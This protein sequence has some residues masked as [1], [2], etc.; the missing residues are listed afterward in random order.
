MDIANLKIQIQSITDL[1]S[2]Y[3]IEALSEIAGF[4][5]NDGKLLYVAKDIYGYPYEGIETDYLKLQTHV[6]ISA[7]KNNQ[8]FE[9]DYYNIIIYK[10]AIDDANLE[11]FV[12]LCSIHS[13]NADELNF[14]EFFYSL[15]ALF[16][17]PAEQ[18]F[19]NVVGLYGELKFMDYVFRQAQIDISNSWHRNGSYSQYDFSNGDQSIEIKTTLSDNSNIAIKHSQIF[20]KHPCHLVVIICEQYENGETVAELISSLYSNS[21]AFNGVNFSINLAKELKRVAMKDVKELRFD[22]K[23]ILFF[24]TIEINP[25]TSSLPDNISSLNYRLDISELNPLSEAD[26]LKLIKQF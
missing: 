4:F 5:A 11:S 22:V 12:Q 3:L 26:S 16:Q 13:G 7:V 6:R 18:S 10:G 8:T 1:S 9:D 15:I 24:N 23:E 17:L 2:I 20:G 21:T 14:K 19:K 25:F